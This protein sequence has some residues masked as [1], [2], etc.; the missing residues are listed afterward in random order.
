MKL[1]TSFALLACLCTS[2]Q[3]AVIVTTLPANNQANLQPDAGQTFTTTV[4]GSENALSTIEIEGPQATEGGDPMGPFVLE[5]WTD[6]DGDHATWDPGTLLASS[7]SQSMTAG[8]A[9]LSTFSFATLPVLADSTPYAFVFTDGAANNVAARFG[10]TDASDIADGTLFGGG[11]QQFGNNFDTAMRITTV[12][13][14]PTTS[15]LALLSAFS[16]LRRRR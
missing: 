9:T 7:D 5:L 1:T 13:P 2:G 4:L 14:E 3:A 6:G 10:L 15:L 16:L 11:T 12:I 8:G